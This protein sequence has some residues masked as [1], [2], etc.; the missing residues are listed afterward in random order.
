M[1][2]GGEAILTSD[3]PIAKVD[4]SEVLNIEGYFCVL[5]LIVIEEDFG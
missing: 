1:R 2:F 5:K 3:N 4:I